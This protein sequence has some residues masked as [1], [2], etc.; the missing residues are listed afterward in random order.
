[1]AASYQGAALIAAQAASAAL[2]PRRGPARGV[3][4]AAQAAPVPP[5][6]GVR[7]RTRDNREYANRTRKN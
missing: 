7:R 3:A 2:A 5:R 4:F 1:L 6:G